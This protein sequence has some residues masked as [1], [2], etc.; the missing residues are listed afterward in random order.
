MLL[1]VCVIMVVQLSTSQAAEVIMRPDAAD[2]KPA[3]SA[4]PEAA[5]PVDIPAENVGELLCS[6]SKPD[7][8]ANA[9][10][11]LGGGLICW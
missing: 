8:P 4:A 3:D 1:A 5:A 2:S 7:M 11:A 6:N 9:P 10:E